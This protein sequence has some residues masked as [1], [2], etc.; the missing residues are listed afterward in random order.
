MQVR[1]ALL[2][3]IALSASLSL[4]VPPEP[5]SVETVIESLRNNDLAERQR[6]LDTLAAHRASSE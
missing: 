4:A 6:A 1:P 3:I 2:C 5:A